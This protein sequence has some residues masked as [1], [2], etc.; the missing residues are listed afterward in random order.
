MVVIT[1]YFAAAGA[2]LAATAVSAPTPADAA[3][4]L[5]ARDDFP[6]AETRELVTQLAW[7]SSYALQKSYIFISPNWEINQLYVDSMKGFGGGK[8][9]KRAWRW[10]TQ[11]DGQKVPNGAVWICPSG[12]WFPYFQF[13]QSSERMFYACPK[14]KFCGIA[15]GGLWGQ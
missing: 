2:L 10:K 15:N 6:D 13:A 11:E 1:K 5:E 3:T 8:C 9:D 12:G 14:D 7:W 4:A